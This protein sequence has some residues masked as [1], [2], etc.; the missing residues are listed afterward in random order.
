M[1]ELF[2]TVHGFLQKEGLAGVRTVFA[3]ILLGTAIGMGIFYYF[4]IYRP[5]L[6]MHKPPP[7]FSPIREIVKILILAALAVWIYSL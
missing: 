4:W 2:V 1:E 6:R 3:A 5:F 7:R